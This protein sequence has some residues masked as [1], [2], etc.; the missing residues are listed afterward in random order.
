MGQYYRFV[1]KTRNEVS[2]ISLPFNFGLPHA[3]SLERYETKE[4]DAMFRFVVQHNADWNEHDELVAIGDYGDEVSFHTV[5]AEEP[6][7]GWESYTPK[8]E[9]PAKISEGEKIW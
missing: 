9:P 6:K 7:F 2:Q 5:R 3:K 4:V 8:P 1:N